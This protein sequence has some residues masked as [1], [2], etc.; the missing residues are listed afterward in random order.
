M[1]EYFD[2]IYKYY[3]KSISYFSGNYDETK[4]NIL[5]R[6][7]LNTENSKW[8]SFIDKC[9][10]E[11]G[12]DSVEDKTNGEPGHVLLI[13]VKTNEQFYVVVWYVARIINAFCFR[14]Q[15]LGRDLNTIYPDFDYKGPKNWNFSPG[16]TKHIV[17]RLTILMNHYFP[18][19]TLFNENLDEIVPSVSTMV[20]DIGDAT[21][22]NIFFSNNFY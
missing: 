12:L 14:V 21:V 22:F 8:N 18:D 1:K 19:Y 20:H 3:P 15:P 11:Y 7:L 10:A 16:E 5:L 4:E 9:I 2:T 6:K 17:D 13:T